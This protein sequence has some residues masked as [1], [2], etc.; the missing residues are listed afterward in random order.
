MFH[1]KITAMSDSSPDLPSLLISWHLYLTSENKSAS[2]I[3][4]Y[5]RNTRLYLT[6]CEKSGRPA[7]I[8][9][10]AVQ[11]YTAEA[12]ANGAEATTAK[13]RLASI[14]RFVAWLVDEGELAA[15]PLAG[16]K[17][18][19]LP[20]KVV[21]ALSDDQ[22]RDLIKACRG[23]S[24]RDRRDEAIVRLMAET[25]LRASE[26]TGL[27]VS[28]VNLQRGIL[29]VIRGKGAKGRIV[30]F[31]PQAAT[32]LD[33]YLRQARK[34]HPLAGTDALWLG[35][36]GKQFG[37]YGLNDTMKDRAQTAGIERFHL[38]LLRHTAATRW[39]RAGGSESALMAVAGWSTRDMID[40]YTG[41]SASER[42]AEES[43]GLNLGNL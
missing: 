31:S 7:E 30:P 29:T 20:A 43:R 24:F 14:R 32:A 19:R 6:W 22:L 2:T 4:T 40:R 38:H 25:G 21:D 26:V 10:E 11:A 27:K 16:M 28:D 34:S 3:S 39:L 8:T 42:A 37:Y 36:G 13:I 17:P 35:V 33:R 23:T 18:P 1:V 12:L 9:R 41:A 15:D 5:L